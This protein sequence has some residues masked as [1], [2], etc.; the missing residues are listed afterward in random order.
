MFQPQD[1]LSVESR[2]TVSAVLVHKHS[3]GKINFQIQIL[4]QGH[5]GTNSATPFRLR[6]GEVITICGGH[7]TEG[8]LH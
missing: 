2:S 6:K 1:T 4:R 5:H 8:Y 7:K 3:H